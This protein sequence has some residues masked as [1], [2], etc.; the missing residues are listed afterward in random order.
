[1]PQGP[2]PNRRELGR[3]F[4]IAQVG[5][6]L[7]APLGVGL[8]LDYYFHWSPWGVVGGAVLGL[9]VGLYHLVALSNQEDGDSSRPRRKAP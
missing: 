7:V 2:P 4:A 9:V 1:M 8:A 5:M 3:Y 6:E